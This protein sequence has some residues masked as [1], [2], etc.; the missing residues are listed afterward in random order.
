MLKMHTIQTKEIQLPLL[1]ESFFRSTFKDGRYYRLAGPGETQH[2]WEES[3]EKQE[4]C[5]ERVPARRSASTTL[6]SAAELAD[7]AEPEAL[8]TTF[9]SA[10][11]S[12][13]E[14]TGKPGLRSGVALRARAHSAVEQHELIAK[15]VLLL[16]NMGSQNGKWKRSTGDTDRRTDGND[17]G[18]EGEDTER[19]KKA[20]QS[21]KSQKKNEKAK[22][23]SKPSVFSSIHKGKSR[24]KAKDP[25]GASK[26]DT[27]YTRAGHDKNLT[28]KTETPN[29]GVS[30]DE[31]GLSDAE[32]EHFH[33][34][35]E[36]RKSA[37]ETR[38]EQIAS[39][40]SETDINS[41]HSAAE[42]ENLLS[43]V[44]QVI[45]PQQGDINS[46]TEDKPLP[47]TELQV[48]EQ[49]LVL[50]ENFSQE[51][52]PA[53]DTNHSLANTSQE[54]K[55]ISPEEDLNQKLNKSDIKLNFGSGTEEHE[56]LNC[57]LPMVQI[58]SGSKNRIT[59][60]VSE[61]NLKTSSE[62]LEEPSEND[63]EIISESM[64]SINNTGLDDSAN[65]RGS[66]QFIC[67][68]PMRNYQKR[69]SLPFV[70]VSSIKTYPPIHLSYV[71]TT[72]RQLTSLNQSAAPSSFHSP[73]TNQQVELYQQTEKQRAKT[74]RS[75]SIAG[76]IGYSIDWTEKLNKNQPRK[77]DFADY[78]SYG[79][80][81][82]R[83]RQGSQ[84]LGENSPCVHSSP[85]SFHHVF[86]GY[87]LLEKFFTVSGDD[88]TEEAED[89][90]SQ[91]LAKGLLLPFTDLCDEN[92]EGTN[93]SIKPK[94]NK[95]QLYRWAAVSQPSL[96]CEP[97]E[98][99]IQGLCSPSTGEG[100]RRG[101][102][103][104]PPKT[105]HEV[106][107][108]GTG[109]L[110]D[111][112]KHELQEKIFIM[113]EEHASVIQQLLKTIK[114]LRTKIAELERN[115]DSQ[116][117]EFVNNATKL[118][119]VSD[120]VQLTE[121]RSSEGKS[122][123]TSPEVDSFKFRTSALVDVSSSLSL[124]TPPQD[125]SPL[126]SGQ[127][128][129]CRC[130]EKQTGVQPLTPLPLPPVVK[131]QPLPPPQP[132][133]P[134]VFMPSSPPIALLGHGP[135][136]PSPP[137]LPGS[138][139]PLP[140]PLT[141]MG[142]LSSPVVSVTDPPSPPG[143][144]SSPP[145][146][147]PEA[148]LQPSS[149]PHVPL[150][151]MEL[152]PLPLFAVMG[153]PPPPPLP[154]VGPLLSNSLS[155]VGPPPPPPLPDVGPP[156][157]PPLPGVGPLLSNSLPGVGPPP[158]PPLPGVGPL[159]SNSLPGV[160]PPPPLPGVGPLLSNSLPGVGPPPP[161][162]GVGPPPPPPLP[163]VGPP[164]P[165]PGVGPPPPPPLPGVGPPPP[166]PLPG[167]GP[168][169]PPPLPGMK[170]PPPLQPDHGG[171][172][173]LPPPLPKDC[174]PGLAQEKAVIEPPRPMKPLYWSRIQLHAKRQSNG[175]LVWENIEEP[176]VD[177][178]EFVDL[179]SKSAVKEKKKPLS[180]TITKSKSKQ[181]VKLLNNKRSQAVGILMSS[182]HLDMK[183]IRHAVL[184]LDNAVVDLET[185]QALYENKAQKEEIDTIEKHIIST[186]GVENAKPLDK[187]EQFLFHLSQIPNF[188]ER[189]FCILLQSTFSECISS[190]L[191]KL[192]V[193]Q[194]ACITL[195]SNV[196][197]RQILGLV[198]AFGNFMNGGNRTRGQ[199]DGFALDILPKLKDVKSSDNSQSLLCYIVAYYLRHFDEDIGRETS[200]SPLPEPQD[201]FCASQ[202]KFEDFQT[203]L[204]KL[205]KDL[206]ACTSEVEKVCHESSVDHL[207]P[208]KDK[209]ENFLSQAK[210]ELEAQEM[211]LHETQ[212]IFFELTAFFSV[213]PKM[214]EK[215]VSP[216]TFF[217]IWHEFSTDFKD[218]WKKENKV[219]LQERLKAAEECFKQ[220]R[221][222]ASYSVKPK[223][224]SG[225]KAKLNMMI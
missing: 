135:H 9:A 109:R 14:S 65:R 89:F 34:T 6:C 159:L 153:S 183:D 102:A 24:A 134:E 26:E 8:S 199:A 28:I 197:I 87:T 167:V 75:C 218:L 21:R 110:Q 91:L 52:Y 143:S 35:A 97:P 105:G 207:Q 12:S 142:P 128:F 118:N 60:T 79:K 205:R 94:F 71:K 32:E 154:D 192:E 50:E 194:R 63:N 93:S 107:P 103:G 140:P 20:S 202:M 90:C 29:I 11:V 88:P 27:L 104:K 98:G 70:S 141:G 160:G 155:G 106:M 165:L 47:Q 38:D 198:L 85:C 157:P 130:R 48:T 215:E 124:V 139:L 68:G 179:F 217:S 148:D 210:V 115:N 19:A 213:K 18:A 211:K 46:A 81:E 161:L 212:K 40:G 144:G 220:A 31:L 16:K 2:Q 69:S 112:V 125:Y 59:T 121:D 214:G 4:V 150:S 22:P 39:S 127:G 7:R 92:G 191:R 67:S 51:E 152:Q 206:N 84:L 221:E 83:P 15:G 158:P 190:V 219:I 123:Q 172:G 163:G 117:K 64:E 100:P 126:Q 186:S 72:T 116:C 80:S 216:N 193:L 180:D 73:I 113:K 175:S 78:P 49:L 58:D 74:R 86:S 13:P 119:D 56:L 224:G 114:N 95:D 174:V 132:P 187:P 146:P 122:V 25:S 43:N 188:S 17:R 176:S 61:N 76:L 156:P 36:S 181:V 120:A 5:L 1:K 108:S 99:R 55:S 222:K 96:C 168:P 66:R 3:T 204:R 77:A 136:S 149:P 147:L 23:D 145:P 178:D 169:P 53:K 82:G 45:P 138:G 208:F 200:P 101:L 201:L 225:I 182:L 37:L 177:F 164:P 42:P 170:Q 209:M 30:A 185:L 54:Y 223:H 129:V 171:L 62:R 133:L 184:N 57:Q 137:P 33:S 131:S 195:K 10:A 173:S 44:Q 111:D 41:F 166:P 162:P 203:D 151:G 189:V 196:A